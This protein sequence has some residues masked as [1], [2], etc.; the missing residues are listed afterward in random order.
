MDGIAIA[1]TASAGLNIFILG[2][3]VLNSYRIGK[4]EGGL[5]NGGYARC[6]FYKGHINKEVKAGQHAKTNQ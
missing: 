4:I 6:P 1:V 5:R 3:V 2:A